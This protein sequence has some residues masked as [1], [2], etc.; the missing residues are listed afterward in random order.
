MSTTLNV[1]LAV[2][3]ITVV[4]LGALV[5]GGVPQNAEALS[6]GLEPIPE[7]GPDTLTRPP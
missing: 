4:A 1:E 5:V 2:L 7:A 3:A 6:H